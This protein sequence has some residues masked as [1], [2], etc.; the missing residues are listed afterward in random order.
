VESV[1]VCDEERV[2]NIYTMK[3]DCLTHL[4]EGVKQ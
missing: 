4:N 3:G 2:V 1:W